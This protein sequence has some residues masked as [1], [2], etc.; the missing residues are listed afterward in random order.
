ML[1]AGAVT[2]LARLMPWHLYFGFR[3]ENRIHK[4]YRKLIMKVLPSPGPGLLASSRS[5]PEKLFEY[6]AEAREYIPEIS[7]SRKTA[8]LQS[9]MAEL[10]V[11]AALLNITE[12]FVSFGRFL[13]VL[14]SLL[15][16]RISIWVKLQGKFSVSFF[17]L[18]VACGFGHAKYFV[19]ITLCH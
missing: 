13:K 3:A 8:L 5:E 19:I 10:I 14:F 2:S 4:T 1:G 16:T 7:E 11:Q 18:V 12:H 9:G 15:I 17:N 6:I